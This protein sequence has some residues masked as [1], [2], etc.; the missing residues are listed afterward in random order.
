MEISQEEMLQ[1][2]RTFKEMSTYDFSNY[3]Y[4]SF[5]RRVEKILTDNNITIQTLINNISKDYNYLENTVN[6]ITV[7][8]TELFRDPE[9]WIAA[10]EIIVA[11]YAQAEHINIWHAGCSSGQEVYSMLM[12][13][14][15]I[16]LVDRVSVFGTDINE[17]MLEASQYGTYKYIDIQEY[18]E[19]FNRVVN[20]KRPEEEYTPITKYVK[21]LPQRDTIQM[22][23]WLTEIPVFSKHDL[24]GCHPFIDKKF[25]IIACRNVLIYFNHELQNKII[26][27]FYNCLNNGGILMMG[28]QESI[29]GSQTE[30]FN[31]FGN[32][33]IKK[34][35]ERQF[36][37]IQIPKSPS[38]I[39]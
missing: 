18:I 30:G 36:S 6:Q 11:K 17:E 26:N 12:L 22:D 13:L 20:Q 14:N 38:L 7:N 29:Y 21:F 37:A 5:Y 3:S 10:R 32:I 9:I 23:K 24:V 2:I 33:Y 4:K 28:R 34:K 15:E 35:L 16:N 27:F 31:K 1:L 39:R 25:D 19:N 8:T